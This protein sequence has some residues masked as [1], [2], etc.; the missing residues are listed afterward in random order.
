FGNTTKASWGFGLAYDNGVYTGSRTIT[1]KPYDA[2]QF[3]WP[4]P[5]D[6]LNTNEVLKGQQNPGY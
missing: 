1:N 4:I 6:E 2:F 3:I 5:L